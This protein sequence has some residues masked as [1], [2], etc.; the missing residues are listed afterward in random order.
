VQSAQAESPGRFVL[1]DH[2]L[3]PSSWSVLAAA[4]GCGEPRLALRGGSVLAPR[5]ERIARRGLETPGSVE[6][7]GEAQRGRAFDADRTVLITGGTGGLGSLLARHLVSEHGVRHLL[8]ASR[9]GPRAPAAA[10][11]EAELGEM[12]A[13][14]RVA[15]CDVGVRDQLERLLDSIDEAHPLGAVVHTAAVMDNGLLDALTPERID[16][17]LAPKADAAWHLHELTAQMDLSAFVLFSSVAGMFGGPGQGNYAAANL[18]LD[19]L[20]EHRRARGLV[21]TS[22]VWGLWSEA[23]VGTEMGPV[24]MRRVVGSAS[25]GMLSSARGLELFDLAVSGAE[26]IVLAAQL[27]M[28]VLRAEARAGKVEGPLRGLV[29]ARPQQQPSA[30][31]GS[32]A[33]RLAA[34][35]EEERM[36]AL[37]AL[38]RDQA[39]EILGLDSAKAIGPARPFKELGFDSLAAVELRNHLAAATDLRLPATLV[40]DYPTPREIVAYL[41]GELELSDAP[42]EG[43]VD[44]ALEEIEGM[45]SAVAQHHGERRRVMARLRACLSTLEDDA[46]EDDLMTASDDEMFEIL[47][48]ELGAL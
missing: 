6:G 3:E 47:D 20:A 12:G 21:A 44:R 7:A 26:T 22:L 41:L 5:L 10:E 35:A 18:F 48:T 34:M 4:L 43:S 30:E 37:L 31:A 2:D 27:D 29:H 32:L 19:R 24:E 15:A 8:L 23:G 39:A 38:V 42:G 16:G 13:H 17:V 33:R 40:F 11:L 1:V 25:M 45:I 28:A 46:G 14:V 36:D 9:S